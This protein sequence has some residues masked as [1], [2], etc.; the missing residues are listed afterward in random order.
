[1]LNRQAG[2]FE[3]QHAADSTRH[4]CSAVSCTW[5]IAELTHAD[6]VQ[7]PSWHAMHM[8]Q[9]AGAAWWHCNAVLLPH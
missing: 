3:L 1:M 7:Q 2:S 9:L 8:A 5:L 4:A 6:T